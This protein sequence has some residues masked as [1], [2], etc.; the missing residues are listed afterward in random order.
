MLGANCSP[1]C[2]KCDE[3]RQYGIYLGLSEYL[4]PTGS[5]EG[6]YDD[7][8]RSNGDHC[9]A[10]VSGFIRSAPLSKTC[11]VN[12]KGQATIYA[13]AQLDNIGNIAGLSFSPQ[14]I[15]PG[16]FD[17]LL[18]TT[19]VDAETVDDDS[20]M[21]YL[22][23]PYTASNDASCGPYGVWRATIRWFFV[24]DTANPLP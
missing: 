12:R 14:G 2:G 10:S 23:I 1:C 15:C 22:K 24:P 4:E 16:R 21:V 17:T 5:F 9:G 18:Q 20:G 19:T 3:T 11:T 7:T 13:G 6:R 8:C